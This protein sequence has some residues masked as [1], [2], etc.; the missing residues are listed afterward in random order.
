MSG[1]ATNQDLT[2]WSVDNFRFADH[3]LG[4]PNVKPNATNSLYVAASNA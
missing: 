2:A 1:Y 4:M 3:S